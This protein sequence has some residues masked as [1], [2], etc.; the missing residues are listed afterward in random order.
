M[1]RTH[2]PVL[3]AVSAIVRRWARNV[4]NVTNRAGRS[5]TLAKT[6]AVD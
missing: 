6:S 4:I 1:G 5:R 2:N 3:L